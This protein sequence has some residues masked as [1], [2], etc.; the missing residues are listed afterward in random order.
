MLVWVY[1]LGIYMNVVKVKDVSHD[2]SGWH[3]GMK[4]GDKILN[5]DGI[6][7]NGDLDMLLKLIS[8]SKGRD[9]IP[10]TV[11]RK[12]NSVVGTIHRLKVKGGELG[13]QL[14]LV[15]ITNPVFYWVLILS[16][17]MFLFISYQSAM[18]GPLGDAHRALDKF[19][20]KLNK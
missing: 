5:Y 12:I 19:N 8:E 10:L 4:K 16:F 6:I 15:K 1:L 9:E 17:I 18:D 3:A 2:S 11:E 13:V 20:N 14:F 7:I